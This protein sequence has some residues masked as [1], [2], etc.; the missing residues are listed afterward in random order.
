[1]SVYVDDMY[2]PFRGMKMCHMTADTLDELHAMADRIGMR[3]DWFQDH[4]HPHYD[5]GM[6]LRA[7]AVKAGAV[8]VKFGWEPWR[9]EECDHAKL[10]HVKRLR[11]ECG[12]T[13]TRETQ[14][15]PADDRG[16]SPR[17]SIE[18][19]RGLVGMD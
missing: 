8:E 11:C 14:A 13:E 9:C 10:P 18:P 16:T 19:E 12:T 1:M 5:V 7:K 2:A 17:A 4:N 15:T 6:G 3:R